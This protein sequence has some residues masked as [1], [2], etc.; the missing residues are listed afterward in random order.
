MEYHSL[1]KRK[2]S[3]LAITE[4]KMD[5][6]KAALSLSKNSNFNLLNVSTLNVFL[7]KTLIFK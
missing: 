4:G 7:K 3:P 5:Y 2:I 1:V 6:K